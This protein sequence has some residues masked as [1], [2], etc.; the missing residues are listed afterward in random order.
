MFKKSI[1]KIKNFLRINYKVLLFYITIIILFTVPLSYEVYTPGGLVSLKDRIHIEGYKPKGDFNLTYVGA[2]KG[3]IPIILLSYI[4]PNWDLIPLE[5]FRIDNEEFKEIEK[6]GKLEL[7]Q[8]NQIATLLAFK[9]ANQEYK[10]KKNDIYVLHVFEDAKT[11]LEVGDKLLEINNKKV[12]DLETLLPDIR[13]LPKGTHI[14]IKV[15]RNKK[16]INRTAEIYTYEENNIIGILLASIPDIITNPKIKLKYMKREMG[17]SG[18]LMTTLQI[19]NTLIDED[20]TK[21]LKISGTGT[22]NIDGTIGEISGVK[23]KL[24]GAV[25]KKADVFIAPTNNYKEAI[26]EKKKNNYNIKIIEADNF[27]NI[28]KKLKDM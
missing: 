1:N 27:D 23:Y 21:G 8:M 17:P 3:I 16:I 11:N 12:K 20:I 14:D 6:R 10:I 9:K 25:K 15:L 22:I 24:A 4:V 13:K 7:R 19:Y 18:G 26:K 5:E 2:K 28:V